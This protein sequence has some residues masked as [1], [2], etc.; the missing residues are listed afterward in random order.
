MRLGFVFFDDYF[1][2]K[3]IMKYTFGT[4]TTAADRLERI[5]DFFNPLAAEWFYFNTVSVWPI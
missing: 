3:T 4:T 2:V 5:A 1:L